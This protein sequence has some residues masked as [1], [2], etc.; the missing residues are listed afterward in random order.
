LGI[1]AEWCRAESIFQADRNAVDSL[2]RQQSTR[3]VS[4]H[5]EN[6][7]LRFLPAPAEIDRDDIRLAIDHEE[8]WEHAHIIFDALGPERLD[9]RCIVEL[10]ADHPA[11]REKMA[12]LNRACSVVD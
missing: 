3:Y 5:P 1:F 4:S 8:D 11:M 7:Q 12:S 10:L 9:W 2:D 6:F